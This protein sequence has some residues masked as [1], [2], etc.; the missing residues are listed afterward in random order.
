MKIQQLSIENRPKA[1]AL[2]RRVF[3]GRGHEADLVQRLHAKDKPLQEWVCLHTGKVIAYIAFSNAYQGNSVCGLHLSSL[4]VSPE[5]QRQGV[6]AELLRFALRQEQIK[7][8]TL[9]VLGAP[10][11]FQKFGF[12]PCQLPICPLVKNNRHFLSIRNQMTSSFQV[13]YEAEFKTS[14]KQIKSSSPAK[15]KAKKR[16]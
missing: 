7:S 14:A 1:Y 10:G 4:A 12:E 3:P 5:F 15:S 2:L 6:G 9:F 16:P 8:Q 11:F 13:G